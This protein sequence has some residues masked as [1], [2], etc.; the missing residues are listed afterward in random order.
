MTVPSTPLGAVLWEEGMALAPQHFQQMVLRQEQYGAWL[1]ATLSPYAWGIVSLELDQAVLPEGLVRVR[2]LQ[3][4][5][6]DGLPVQYRDGRDPPLEI[7][8]RAFQETASRAPV[9]VHLTVPSGRSITGTGGELPRF[10]VIEASDVEDE[11]GGALPI[12]LRRLRPRLGLDVTTAPRQRPPAKFVSL[13]FLRLAHDGRVFQQAP[14]APPAM[15]VAERSPLWHKVQDVL[16]R[17]REKAHHFARQPSSRGLSADRSRME[18]EGLSVGLPPLEALLSSGRAHPFAL[19][20]ELC[21]YLGLISALA[22]GEVPQAA[23]RYDHDDPLAAF[24]EVLA[25]VERALDRTQ[26][27]YFPVRFNAEGAKFTL[28]LDPAW[29]KGPMLVGLRAE[30]GRPEA[31][32]RAWMDRALIATRDRSQELWNLRIRGA[33]R[34][35][36]DAE[37]DIGLSPPPGTLLFAIEPDSAYVTESEALEI[38]NA[39]ARADEARP[40]DIMLFV[41][42]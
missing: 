28:L 21:R 9:T 35:V 37:A 17:A 25:G 8:V 4:L 10:D 29:T 18:L 6:P 39:D 23:P 12:T 2:E 31:A 7:E 42:G 5:L 16:R 40:L 22:H 24:D 20:I 34:R 32:L 15:F 1:A 33:A 11:A 19:Y 27:A 3:A 41:L 38:W 30:S 26:R 14:F 13:P 36:V